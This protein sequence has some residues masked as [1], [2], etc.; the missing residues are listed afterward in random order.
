[1]ASYFNLNLDT[2]ATSGLIL[3]INDGALYMTSAAVT[4][5]IGLGDG[6]TGG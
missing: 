5:A 3:A 4:L 2:T 6:D 1:M